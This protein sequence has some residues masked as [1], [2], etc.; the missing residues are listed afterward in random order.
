MSAELNVVRQQAAQEVREASHDREVSAILTHMW[1]NAENLARQEMA[2]GLKEID[3]RV[4]KLK[5][6]LLFGTIG[7]ATLYAGILVL[8]AAV[9]LG[10]SK[11]MEP[12]LAALI[13]GGLVTGIGAT[14]CMRGETK[15]VQAVTPDEHLHRTTR[16]M[17]EA[18]K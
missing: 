15:A 18:I 11:V 8:L 4:D 16:A 10:L 3:L 12:W 17:K 9:V 6:S 7:G 5:Q 2:L 14:L 13:V 1:E